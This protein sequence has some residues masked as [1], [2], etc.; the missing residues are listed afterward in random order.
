MNVFYVK[1]HGPQIKSIYPSIIGRS[2]TMICCC[3]FSNYPSHRYYFHVLCKNASVHCREHNASGMCLCIS[4]LFF[5]K[6]SN[7]S[8]NFMLS[9]LGYIII[10]IYGF[11]ISWV[12]RMTTSSFSITY[13]S[14][15]TYW[16]SLLHIIVISNHFV[17]SL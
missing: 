12:W 1:M 16:L 9:M 14:Y 6:C 15:L 2:N 11:L 8:L 7:H 10:L 17:C 3:C 4:H 13:L 5:H